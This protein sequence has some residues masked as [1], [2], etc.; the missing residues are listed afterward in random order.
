ML[1]KLNRQDLTNK[2]KGD[3][4]DI[5]VVL[6]DL[7]GTLVTKD[8]LDVLC[9][10][11]GEY[12]RSAEISKAFHDGQISG[13]DSVTQRIN[14]L[15]GVS[16][17]EIKRKLAENPYL[18]KGSKELMKFLRAKGITTILNSGQIIPVLQFYQ[19]I[20]GVD[21]IVGTHPDIRDGVIRGISPERPIEK[22]FKLK[23][24]ISILNKLG[25]RPEQII[26]IG[27]SLADRKVFDYA[28]LSITV[29]P[30]GGIEKYADYV[31][32]QDLKDTIPIIKRKLNND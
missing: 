14:L 31:I 2:R 13:V 28:A 19:D 9:S 21:Y 10:L 20:L 12:K 24:C 11:V 26:A 8:L 3:D 5:R 4:M 18:R 32:R 30:K 23:G 15:S 25:I 6:L 16:V 27:D 1:F 29:D 22:G 17:E 7:D